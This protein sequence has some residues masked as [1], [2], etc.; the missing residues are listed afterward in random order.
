MDAKETATLTP[1]EFQVYTYLLQVAAG[2]GSCPTRREIGEHFSFSRT[3]ADGYLKS[4]ERK[5]F[6]VLSRGWRGITI[7][8]LT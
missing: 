4:I 8:E 5:G 1:R 7:K 6:I 2:T 3:T